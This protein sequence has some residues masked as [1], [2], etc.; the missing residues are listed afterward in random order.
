[1]QFTPDSGVNSKGPSQELTQRRPDWILWLSCTGLAADIGTLQ[2]LHHVMGNNSLA[3]ELC[4]TA[5]RMES[6]EAKAAGLVSAVHEDKDAML[7]HAF[8][9]AHTI[10]SKSPVSIAG[11]KVN[12]NHSRENKIRDSLEYV[13]NWNA[14]ML[15][16][17]DIPKAAMAS[18]SKSAQPD[19]SKL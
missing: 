3:R 6:A 16:T 2:R 15:Q 11:T 1:M 9:L 7:K 10:A 13:A 4:Y 18:M 17:D 12:L 8:E 19:F 14:G 5:R